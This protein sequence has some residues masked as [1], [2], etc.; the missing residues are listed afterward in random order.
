MDF[1]RWLIEAFNSQ[2][3]IG[4]SALLVR[5]VVGNI[6]GLA[7][8]VGGMRRK[9][10][11]WPVGIIGNL[12][13]LTVFLGSLFDTDYA[14]NLWGQAGRQIMFIAV[15]VFGWYRWK[16]A[17]DGGGSAV[18]PKWASNKVRLGLVSFLI[19]GTVAL[20]PLFR[21]LGSYEPVW[22]DAWTFV[23]SLL[24]TFGMAKGWV[25]FWLIWVAVDAVGVPL[26]FSAG[27]YA[28]AF[29]YLFYGAFT[30]IGFFVWARA[31]KED[32]PQIETEM[33]DPTI[34]TQR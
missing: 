9:V 1:L 28:S 34:Q 25:E 6:F 23:G 33:P 14:A 5:E 26:L 19:L 21:I 4:S 7:S 8:A 20:T 3:A 24:A 22:A 18:T 31:K 15:S 2:I 29:M 27:Y 13:L 32:K 11:A 10:W 16:Q 12:L 17:R 30:L